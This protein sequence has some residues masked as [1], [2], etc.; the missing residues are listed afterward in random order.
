MESEDFHQI[1]HNPPIT[2]HSAAPEDKER[3]AKGLIE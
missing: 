1:P 3:G 2:S